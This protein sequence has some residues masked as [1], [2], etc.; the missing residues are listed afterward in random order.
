MCTFPFLS[1]G[2]QKILKMQQPPSFQCGVCVIHFQNKNFAISYLSDSLA[3]I[4]CPYIFKKIFFPSNIHPALAITFARLSL[5]A[6]NASH[7]VSFSKRKKSRLQLKQ[8]TYLMDL[9]LFLTS[10]SFLTDF[11]LH[12][13]VRCWAVSVTSRGS[14]VRD[15]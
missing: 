13:N 7:H 9:F 3:P 6:G 10:G 11:I 1:R 8:R 2:P 12:V 5:R 4:I 14:E 15:M